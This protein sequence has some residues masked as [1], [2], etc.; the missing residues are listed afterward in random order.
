M[1]GFGMPPVP[2]RINHYEILGVDRNATPEEI[3][4]ACKKLSLALHPD[5]RPAEVS[6]ATK[7]TQQL[8]SSYDILKDPEKRQK[9]DLYE[10]ILNQNSNSKY[11]FKARTDPF[12]KASSGQPSSD[13]QSYEDYFREQAPKFR[14]AR[15]SGK[16]HK[17]QDDWNSGQDHK[18]QDDWSRGQDQGTGTG[19]RENRRY[20]YRCGTEG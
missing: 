4:A 11:G 19:K 5:K 2:P 12:P 8:N 20:C 6:V 14:K 17:N 15:S 13:G 1:T 3:R 10:E 7:E 18:N 16:D 9:Y